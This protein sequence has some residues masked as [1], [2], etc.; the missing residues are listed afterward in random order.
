[1]KRASFLCVTIAAVLGSAVLSPAQVVVY[2]QPNDDPNGPYSDGVPGQYAGHRIADNFQLTDPVNR[3]VTTIVWWG[4][5]DYCCNAPDLTN[6][7]DWI[8]EI[9]EDDGGLPGDPI[10]SETFAKEHTNYIPTG[11]TNGF[12]GWE[13]Q[14]TVTLST[15]VTL[16]IDT[17]YWISIGAV[18]A[19]PW[20]DG[21]LWSRN[22]FDGD[23]ALAEDWFDGQGY[24]PRSGDVAFVLYGTT[25]GGCPRPGNSGKGCTA[26][27]AGDDCVVGL[28]DLGQLLAHYGMITG[29]VHDDGDIEPPGG[30]GDVDLSD[31]NELLSQYGD[32]CSY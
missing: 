28:A 25:A 31:L 26:D 15:P 2:S 1:M 3:R 12:G 32:D 9:Y 24:R 30:D 19:D 21:W 20:G 14:Q 27:I 4:G 8:V 16:F 7:T 29:A 5:S 23:D 18:A 13:Y 17:P 6:F 22:Y 11:N 10:Y